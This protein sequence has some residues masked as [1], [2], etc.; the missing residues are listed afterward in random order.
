MVRGFRDRG[1]KGSFSSYASVLIYR[2]RIHRCYNGIFHPVKRYGTHVFTWSEEK[3]FCTSHSLNDSGTPMSKISPI[4]LSN[5]G[6]SSLSTVH[7]LLVEYIAQNYQQYLTPHGEKHPLTLF[8][9]LR[10]Y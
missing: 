8:Q 2:K 5:W 9:L 10:S 7:Q 6:L 1:S 4:L 3:C